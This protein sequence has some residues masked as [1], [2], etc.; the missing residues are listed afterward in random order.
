MLLVIEL[1]NF[2]ASDN[3]TPELVLNFMFI[4][5]KLKKKKKIA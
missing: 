4:K 3:K 5:S 2:M 1:E